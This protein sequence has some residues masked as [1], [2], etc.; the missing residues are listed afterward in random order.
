MIL[1]LTLKWSPHSILTTQN[2]TYPSNTWQPHQ[3]HYAQPQASTGVSKQQ[4][5]VGFS[6]QQTTTGFAQQMDQGMLSRPPTYMPAQFGMLERQ[7]FPHPTHNMGGI[8]SSNRTPY[9]HAPPGFT[10]HAP[11]STLNAMVNITLQQDRNPPRGD[12]ES[13]SYFLERE[14]EDRGFTLSS[15]TS[16]GYG[17]FKSKPRDN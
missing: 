5:T 17:G 1:M 12:F 15:S 13:E 11:N 10:T 6:Q 4:A 8:G 14:N 2:L 7:Q 16:Q 9:T 3:P